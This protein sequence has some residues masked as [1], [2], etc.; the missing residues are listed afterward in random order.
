MIKP[1]THADIAVIVSRHGD[2]EIM[3]KTL[4]RFGMRVI[5]GAG[6]AGRRPK[7]RGGS[8]ALRG[9]LRALKEGATFAMTADVPPGPARRA[10][11]G[12]V[13][14]AK[15]SGRP[16]VPCAFATNR[17]IALD[18]WSN[19]TI[20]L[21][22]SSLAIVVGQPLWVASGASPAELESA[23][24]AVE[25]SLNH[26]TKRAY[27]LSDSKDPYLKRR[28]LPDGMVQSPTSLP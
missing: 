27:Q 15:L 3:A 11:E 21:P 12:I 2:A 26:V 20:N 6:D 7:N 24:L 16:I 13:L 23:R 17:Y 4:Q 9:A 22:L 5:R 19:F 14:L 1:K 10:G 18:S 28:A 8:A 25:D